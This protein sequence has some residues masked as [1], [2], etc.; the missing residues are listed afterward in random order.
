MRL[1]VIGSRTISNEKFVFQV[2]D[3]YKDEISVLITGGAIG[4]DQI[5][6]RW[7]LQNGIPTIL[8]IPDWTKYGK[9]AGIIRNKLI[10]YDCDECVAF[11]DGIS[12]GTKSTI[13]IC[14]KLKK[15]INIIPI[16]KATM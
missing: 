1:A 4:I 2:L 13:D 3:S 15:S 8:H 12:K 5:A 14:T 6:E 9:S 10:V 16:E 11:W 7:A